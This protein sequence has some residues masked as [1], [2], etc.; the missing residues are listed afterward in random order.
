MVGALARD[1][2]L[3]QPE[4]SLRCFFESVHDGVLGLAYILSVACCVSDH[5]YEIVESA[6]DFF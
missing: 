3:Y 5:V 6:C 1:I 2:R 4:M